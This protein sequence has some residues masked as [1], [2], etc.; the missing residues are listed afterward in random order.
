M[1]PWFSIKSHAFIQN[2]EP[3]ASSTAEM[4]PHAQRFE[5]RQLA[6]YG[7]PC[8]GGV[9]ICALCLPPART[10]VIIL[11]GG[12]GGNSRG[13]FSVRCS[14]AGSHSPLGVEFCEKPA[15]APAT[16]LHI[17]GLCGPARR[18]SYFE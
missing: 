3:M 11:P 18:S 5:L 7:W 12:L 15:R 8:F 16:P 10:R 14:A 4:I 1:P 6:G 13:R 9:S 2:S 17:V